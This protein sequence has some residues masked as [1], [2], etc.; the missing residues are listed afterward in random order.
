MKPPIDPKPEEVNNDVQ[1]KIFDTAEEQ[2]R[3]NAAAVPP[4]APAEAS[5]FRAGRYNQEAMTYGPMA[6]REQPPFMGMNMIMQM[7]QQNGSQQQ[8]NIQ[9]AG[10]VPCIQQPPEE[11]AAAKSGKWKCQ[12]GFE[13]NTGKFCINCGNPRPEG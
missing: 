3:V 1:G 11:P 6:T 8:E 13:D 10:L 12:C 5:E 7:M 2:E 4:P 9:L